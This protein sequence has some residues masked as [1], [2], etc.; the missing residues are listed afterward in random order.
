M[1]VEI[2]RKVLSKFCSKGDNLSWEVARMEQLNDLQTMLDRLDCP[3]F[4]VQDG[5]ISAVNAGAQQRMAEPGFNIREILLSGAEE[6][7]SFTD[8]LLSAN[9]VK[10]AVRPISIMRD[11][12]TD[13]IR[14]VAH[15]TIYSS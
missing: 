8:G 4:L 1:F 5:F 13:I 10:P 11:N 15:F 9:T 2:C 7:E 3:A 14:F 6:Y 12:K